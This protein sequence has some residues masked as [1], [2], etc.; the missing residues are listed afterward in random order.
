MGCTTGGLTWM[1]Y[2]KGLGPVW[3]MAASHVALPPSASPTV[4]DKS[5][6]LS[7]GTLRGCTTHVHVGGSFA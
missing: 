4:P 5:S 1:T 6:E 3:K 7:R 2:P